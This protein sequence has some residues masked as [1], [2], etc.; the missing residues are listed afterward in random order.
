MCTHIG[1]HFDGVLQ[2]IGYIFVIEYIFKSARIS[3]LLENAT[4]CI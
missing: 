4:L 1:I 3:Y 2:A